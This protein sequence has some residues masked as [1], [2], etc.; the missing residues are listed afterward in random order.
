[1]NLTGK[2]ARKLIKKRDKIDKL[3]KVLEGTL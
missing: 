2:K 3:Y 1:M